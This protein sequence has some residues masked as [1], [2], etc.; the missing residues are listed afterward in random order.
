MT[1]AIAD[2]F[3][4]HNSV[5]EFPLAAGTLQDDLVN[6]VAYAQNA[7]AK[8]GHRRSK[9]EMLMFARTIERR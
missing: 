9:Q 3:F 1:D 4:E 2:S 5:L 7:P 8:P 6:A